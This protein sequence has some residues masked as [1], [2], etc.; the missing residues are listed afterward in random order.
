MAITTISMPS[1]S[2]IAAY[3]SLVRMTYSMDS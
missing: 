3:C 1:A 2:F